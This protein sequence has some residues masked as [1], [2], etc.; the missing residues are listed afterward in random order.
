MGQDARR[1]HSVGGHG[2]DTGSRG[3]SAFRPRRPSVPRSHSQRRHDAYRWAGISEWTGAADTLVAGPLG[4]PGCRAAGRRAV[5]G[6]R[7]PHGASAQ[8]SAQY[9]GVDM[10]NRAAGEPWLAQQQAPRH[11]Q[12]TP[13]GAG[14]LARAALLQG[15]RH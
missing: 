11:R 8:W 14:R 9:L 7:L 6:P 3:P 13:T 15:L 12:L 4:H 5:G 1:A 10:T 2:R